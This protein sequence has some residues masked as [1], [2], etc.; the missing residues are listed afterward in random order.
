MQQFFGPLFHVAG[1][2][3]KFWR[4][5]VVYLAI[6]GA[7]APIRPVEAPAADTRGGAMG[8][9]RL[10]RTP[11]PQGG[12]EA[13]SMSHTADMTRSDL[14][15]AGMMLKCGQHGPEIVIVALTP[16]PPRAG[17]EVT[18]SALGKEWRFAASVVPPGAELLLP[19]DAT[20]LAAGPWQSAHE[21]SVRVR[22]KEQSFAG[23]IPIDG[24]AA[25]LATLSA[26]CPV[27]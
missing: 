12:R 26:N 5:L 16:L 13:I 24:L 14:D 10:L 2:N 1:T 15:L 3:A 18:I 11:N 17:P 20:H 4:D 6:A 23:I 21:L 27:G 7:V 22:S 8:G 9:W 19:G 25:A